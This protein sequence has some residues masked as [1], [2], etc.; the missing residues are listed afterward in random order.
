MHRFAGSIWAEQPRGLRSAFF[1]YQPQLKRPI[2][3]ERWQIGTHK[4]QPSGA[5]YK[6]TPM[7]SV[8]SAPKLDNARIGPAQNLHHSS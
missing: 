8:F 4:H 6:N 5:V 1:G 3:R 7:W 2:A